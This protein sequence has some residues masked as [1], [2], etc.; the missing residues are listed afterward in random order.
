MVDPTDDSIVIDDYDRPSGLFTLRRFSSASGRSRSTV[1]TDSGINRLAID[2]R[3]RQYGLPQYGVD[4]NAYAAVVRLD[5]RGKVK[6]GVDFWLQP[7]SAGV[8]PDVP[9]IL[10][11]PTAIA[12]GLDGRVLVVDEPNIDATFAD[13]SPRRSAVVTSLGQFLASP[14]QW[15]LPVEWEFGSQAFGTWSHRLALAGAADASVYVGEP[16][17]DETGTAVVGGRIRHFSADGSLLESWG[18]GVPD[19]GASRPSHPAV[20]GAGRLWVIDLDPATNRSII[21]VLEPG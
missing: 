13:G 18:T 15:E 11:F 14:R 9:G 12:I 5:T 10:A 19:S 8:R 20:D 4:S 3:G 1:Y 16:V 2:A 21:A 6:F 7:L 17:L